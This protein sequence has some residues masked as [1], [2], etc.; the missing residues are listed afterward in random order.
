MLSNFINALLVGGFNHL[1]KY[2]S[3]WEGFHPIYEM[4]N[5]NHV[6]NHQPDLSACK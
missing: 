3:R 5:K 6:P 2:E 4:E 1:E